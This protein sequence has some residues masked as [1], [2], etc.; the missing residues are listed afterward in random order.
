MIESDW[1]NRIQQN[2]RI[3]QGYEHI[4]KDEIIRLHTL[5][6]YEKECLLQ[7]LHYIQPLIK[8]ILQDTDTLKSYIFNTNDIEVPIPDSERRF[9]EHSAKKR[10]DI[11]SSYFDYIHAVRNTNR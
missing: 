6:W 9:P 1:I 8:T 7:Q 10:K 4:L 11:Y 5:T 2:L 3:L